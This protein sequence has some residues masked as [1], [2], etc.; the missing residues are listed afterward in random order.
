MEKNKKTQKTE[1]QQLLDALK[2]H[3][4]LFHGP[5]QSQQDFSPPQTNPLASLFKTSEPLELADNGKVENCDKCPNAEKCVEC[6]EIIRI[7][8]L[9][10]KERMDT[11]GTPFMIN[12]EITP[13]FVLCIPIEKSHNTTWK[14]GPAVMITVLQLDKKHNKME[15]VGLINDPANKMAAI[16]GAHERIP[17]NEQNKEKVI[18]EITLHTMLIGIQNGYMPVKGN[19]PKMIVF[20]K[21]EKIESIKE[22]MQQQGIGFGIV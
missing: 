17:Y 4:E 7:S 20:D 6:G 9:S 19:P 11:Y 22:K 15:F 8:D 14:K 2:K 12:N 13:L 5:K 1:I 21:N 3:E 18:K 16:Y 10:A